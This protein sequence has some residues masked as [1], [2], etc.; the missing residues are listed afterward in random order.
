MKKLSLNIIPLLS[1]L[2]FSGKVNA[3][4]YS[5]LG[6]TKL[7]EFRILKF[8]GYKITK[9]NSYDQNEEMYLAQMENQI[10]LNNIIM[11]DKST[12]LVLGVIWNFN[13]K[14][15]ELTKSLLS[16]MKSSYPSE[17]RKRNKKEIARLEPVPIPEPLS[18]K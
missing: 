17:N 11:I 18:M 9:I 1:I 7:E 8:N 3:Q 6:R 4:D 12:D 10:E 2:L 15:L 13:I 16:E 14:N 5:D